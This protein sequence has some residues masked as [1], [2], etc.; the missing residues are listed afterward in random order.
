MRK[1]YNRTWRIIYSFHK[2]KRM[3]NDDKVLC[4]IEV[5]GKG[6]GIIKVRIKNIFYWK[7]EVEQEDNLLNVNTMRFTFTNHKAHTVSFPAF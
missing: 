5:E 4:A 6:Y 7:V 1:I 2:I 3:M